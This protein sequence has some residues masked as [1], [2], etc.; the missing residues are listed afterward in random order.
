MLGG[1]HHGSSQMSIFKH[2][3]LIAL[4]SMAQLKMLF[5][6]STRWEQAGPLYLQAMDALYPVSTSMASI[7]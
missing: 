7:L 5:V 1:L 2:R 4:Y 3:M 6:V